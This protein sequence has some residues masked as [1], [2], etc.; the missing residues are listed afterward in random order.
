MFYFECT[1]INY[2]ASN[3]NAGIV[4]RED[5]KL[6]CG[7]TAAEEKGRHVKEDKVTKIK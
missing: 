6:I 2:G 3:S 7:T 4:G 1:K 5:M